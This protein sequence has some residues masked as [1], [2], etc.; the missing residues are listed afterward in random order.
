M[1][2]SQDR[3]ARLFA[4]A[5]IIIRPLL[6]SRLHRPLSSQL[7]VLDYT[8]ARSGHRYSFP[9]GYFTWDEDQVL[10]FSSR[11]WPAALRTARDIQ[12]VL[13]G[14]TYDAAPEVISVQE[15]KVTLLAAFAR[16]K[17][18][19]TAK[20]LMLGL[21]GNR[22]PSASELEAAATKTTILRFRLAP[23]TPCR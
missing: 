22:Q 20:R 12:V 1:P 18:P 21:P 2:D 11:R 6:L 9:I 17:G 14:Q 8:G 23:V 19:R 5:S 10:A 4:A 3:L 7:M 15:D 16:R 13:R